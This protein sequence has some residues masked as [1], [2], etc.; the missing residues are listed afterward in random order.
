MIS[1][2]RFY[3]IVGEWIGPRLCSSNAATALPLRDIK[4]KSQHNRVSRSIPVRI[5]KHIPIITGK[6]VRCVE[7]DLLVRDDLSRRL[8]AQSPTNFRVGSCL[9][10]CFFF[11]LST[12]FDGFLT[13][14]SL[15]YGGPSR[16]GIHPEVY[17]FQ[18]R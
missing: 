5:V 6:M 13:Q 7:T 3:Q 11:H 15:I 12:V 18:N 1:R 2:Q 10:H 14:L 17:A 16:G 4:A 9:I 8:L